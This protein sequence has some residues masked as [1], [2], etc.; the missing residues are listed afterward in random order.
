MTELEKNIDDYV[1]DR[2]TVP[3]KAAFEAK[4]WVDAALRSEVQVYLDMHEVFGEEMNSSP[5][6]QGDE[7][8]EE[9]M[10]LLLNK[11][12]KKI[13][14]AIE[15]AG[16]QYFEVQSKRKRTMKGLYWVGIILLLLLLGIAYWYGQ[17]RDYDSENLY[18]SYKDFNTLPSLINRGSQSTL[19]RGE[20]LFKEKKYQEA[21]IVFNDYLE[22]Q[23]EYNTPVQ[24]YLACCL[25]EL[26]DVSRAITILMGISKGGSLDAGIANWYLGLA[27]IKNNNYAKA[28]E[29]ME[30]IAS[31]PQNFN[32]SEADKLLKK[33]QSSHN[34][35]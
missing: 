34:N 1:N 22:D 20:E 27:Y 4:M 30:G 17:S 5:K 35:Q 23:E 33:L 2:L 11:D 10:N 21:S 25:M 13:N 19:A 14:D 28:N 12:G 3:E 8:R 29:I 26:G 6:G 31:D 7:R 9:L 24:L 15:K 16:S 18:A 32:Y